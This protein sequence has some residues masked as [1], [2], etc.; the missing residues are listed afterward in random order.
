MIKTPHITKNH[1]IW[2]FSGLDGN[3]DRIYGVVLKP[4]QLNKTGGK[5]NGNNKGCS[6][7]L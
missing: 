7:L 2:K 3:G 1:M 4:I 5:T 6:K